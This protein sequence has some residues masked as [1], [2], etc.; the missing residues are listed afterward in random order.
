M[1]GHVQAGLTCR[2]YIDSTVVSV[3]IIVLRW[4]NKYATNCQVSL[5]C[6]DAVLDVY[7]Y[8]LQVTIDGVG[9]TVIDGMTT[10]LSRELLPSRE[11][12]YRIL[13][14][15]SAG[16]GMVSQDMTFKTNFSG[17]L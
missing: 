6:D 10:F 11:Y 9:A 8:F 14:I 17:T 3:S 12:T 15:N 5:L 4:A 13:A 7:M 2:I 16:D 1:Y